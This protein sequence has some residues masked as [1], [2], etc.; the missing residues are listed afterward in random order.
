MLQPPPH[1]TLT[2]Q[3]V[4]ECHFYTC[5]CQAV[6]TCSAEGRLLTELGQGLANMANID[7]KAVKVAKHGCHVVHNLLN[8]LLKLRYHD[9][10]T[11]A[12]VSCSTS[13]SSIFA[14]S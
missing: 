10:V 1:A 9:S 7:Y 12:T 13:T 8:M 4:T 3:E 5:A 11:P 14:V 6:G 2:T